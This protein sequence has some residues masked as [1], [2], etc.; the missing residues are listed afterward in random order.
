MKV[1]LVVPGG[2]DRSG[3]ERV[4]PVLLGLI[5]RLSRRHEVHIVALEQEREPG[6]WP[7][8]GA[9]VHNLGEPPVAAG[10]GR[11]AWW[12]R[13]LLHLLG[14]LGRVD[15]LHGFWGEG[16]GFLA[17]LAGRLRGVPTVVSLAGGELVWLPAIGYG[18]LGRPGRSGQVLFAM[19]SASALTVATR[20]MDRAARAHG[21][22]PRLV[23]LGIDPRPFGGPRPPRRPGRFVLASLSSLSPVKDPGTLLQSLALLRASGL[24]AV[25]EA[26]GADVTGGRVAREA[27]A[28][29]VSPFVTFHGPVGEEAVAAILSRADLHVLPSLHDAAPVAV[30]EAAASGVPT[31]GTPVGWVADWA[32]KAAVAVPEGNPVALAEAI[33][34]LL[35]DPDRRA[36]I[37]REARAR[38][39]LADDTAAAFEALYA[40]VARG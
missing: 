4:I 32:P 17:A 3:R 13:R 25:L 5:E 6:E 1:A 40:E 28:L 30:L 27:E 8:L 29:G 24:D 7:L 22:S 31:V 33:R 34:S 20:F 16:A 2:V 14:R 35:L 23:P 39:P 37:A 12:E 19:R 9:T 21:A 11:I 10:P 26:A 36:A 18:S 15:V 38:V